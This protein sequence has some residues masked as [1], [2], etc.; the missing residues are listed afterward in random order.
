MQLQADDVPLVNH[1][2]SLFYYKNKKLL[3]MGLVRLSVFVIS[4]MS[5]I[6]ISLITIYRCQTL[7]N[8]TRDK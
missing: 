4:L 3:L 5:L 7:G 1:T 6:N 2:C 8:L